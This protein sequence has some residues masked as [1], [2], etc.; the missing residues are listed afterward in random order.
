M[1]NPTYLRS[2]GNLFERPSAKILRE[3]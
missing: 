2:D 3:R 1:L